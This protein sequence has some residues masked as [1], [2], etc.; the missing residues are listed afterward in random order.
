[1]PTTTAPTDSAQEPFAPQSPAAPGPTPSDAPGNTGS[2][3]GDTSS[4]ATDPKPLTV[5]ELFPTPTILYNNSTYTVLGKHSAVSCGAVADGNVAAA[6]TKN[7]CNQVVRGTVKDPTSRYIFTVGVANM[8][9]RA[10][11]AQVFT[12]LGMPDKNGF[13]SR[14]NGTDIARGFENNRATI[15]A[16]FTHGHYVIFGIGGR[17]GTNTASLSDTRLSAGLKD[18]RFYVDQVI[19]KRAVVVN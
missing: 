12:L 6:L 7:G 15:V 18:M 8:P 4:R 5:A 14:L 19:S 11:A 16:S 1:M 13:F 2:P 9:T 17:A 3:K 10:A